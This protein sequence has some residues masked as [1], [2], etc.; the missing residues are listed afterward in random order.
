MSET[1]EVHPDAAFADAL[2]EQARVRLVRAV[3]AGAGKEAQA[4]LQALTAPVVD[5]DKTPSIEGE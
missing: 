3:T 4:A 1:V 2:I 5:N